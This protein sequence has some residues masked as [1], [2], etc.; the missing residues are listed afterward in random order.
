MSLENLA[1]DFEEPHKSTTD[2]LCKMDGSKIFKLFRHIGLLSNN[3]PCAWQYRGAKSAM[4]LTASIGRSFHIYDCEKISLLFVGP[5]FHQ[6]IVSLACFEDWTIVALQEE[7]VLC[8]RAKIVSRSPISRIHDCGKITQ[9]QTFGSS[10]LVSYENAFLDHFL[11]P[12]LTLK[13]RMTL[14]FSC[15][16]FMHPPS[17]LDKILICSPHQK[18]MLWNIEKE[19]CIF[20]FSPS[21][22]HDISCLSHSPVADVVAIGLIDG[23]VL[24]YNIRTNSLLFKLAHPGNR[25]TSITFRYHETNCHL[26]VADDAGGIYVWDLNERRI[27][28]TILHAHSLAVHT[29]TYVANSGVLLSVSGDNSIKQWRYEETSSSTPTL[30]KSRSGHQAQPTDFVFYDENEA[31]LLC[32]SRDCTL[33]LF[34]LDRDE[35][36]VEFSQG[37]NEIALSCITRIS[38]N[39]LR[40]KQWDDILTCHE[41]ASFATSWKYENRRLGTHHFATPDNSLVKVSTIS[42][43]GNFALLGTSSGKVFVFNMQSGIMRRQ[44]QAHSKP[45]SALIVDSANRTVFT[46]S[47]DSTVAFWSFADNSLLHGANLD[48]VG[49]VFAKSSANELIAIGCDNFEL[50]VLDFDTHNAVRHFRGHTNRIN[51]VAFSPDGRWLVSCSCDLTIRT[52]DIPTGC[53]IDVL[54]CDRI[55]TGIAFSPQNDFLV[56]SHCGFVGLTVWSNMVHFSQSHYEN[57]TQTISKMAVGDGHADD[58]C[59]LEGLCFSSL[60]KAKW[61]LLFN[62]EQIKLRNRPSSGALKKSE[63]VPFF[64]NTLESKSTKSTSAVDKASKKQTEAMQN[65]SIEN[66]RILSSEKSAVGSNEFSQLLLHRDFEKIETLFSISTA[67][68]ADLQIRMLSLSDEFLELKMFLEFLIWLLASE[69]SFDAVQG[70]LFVVL[71]EFSAVLLE[72]LTEFGSVFDRIVE[73]LEN[74]I[75]ALNGKIGSS[76]CLVD[77]YCS[78][79]CC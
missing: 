43:C 67:S 62:L 30:L 23:S 74:G 54:H 66:T 48:A 2:L 9:I 20:D 3:V 5:S 36:S 37:K 65:V 18:L 58:S 69:R 53:M 17:Y 77:Y 45:I 56:S 71:D 59:E 6:D 4:F 63:E 75:E 35:Q 38:A 15:S 22:P 55:P 29:L 49:G 10:L 12:S 32:A 51:G 72:N 27:I 11:L 64:L 79:Q 25:I 21:I 13:K 42:A 76:L 26:A 46:A 16:R 7:I 33:R 19:K 28:H 50:V 78:N 8:H 14:P 73:L 41:G 24:I 68:F 31:N 47:I 61:E 1:A 52:W 34:C 60:P 39:P 44:W 57:L 40:K 70:Y